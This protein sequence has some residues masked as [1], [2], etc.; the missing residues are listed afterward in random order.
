M[1]ARCAA[2]APWAGNAA[3][4]GWTVGWLGRAGAA[5]LPV[6]PNGPA[7]AGGWVVV[8]AGC[9]AISCWVGSAGLGAVCLLLSAGLGAG[10][11]AAL[12]DEGAALR[13]GRL[14]V[15]R[16]ARSALA[17]RSCAACV[18]MARQTLSLTS[19]H[20]ASWSSALVTSAI[21]ILCDPRCAVLRASC[22]I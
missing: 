20:R 6:A 10:A 8:D 12:G 5:L 14:A 22:C 19:R 9:G 16:A 7:W 17:A 11:I 3:L 13:L 18:S 2:G 15:E 21:F 1:L 4:A